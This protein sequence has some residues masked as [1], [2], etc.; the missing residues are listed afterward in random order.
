MKGGSI[1]MTSDASRA[2]GDAMRVI[3]HPILTICYATR[4]TGQ[5]MKVTSYPKIVGIT[6]GCVIPRQRGKVGHAR[7]VTR[8]S[9]RRADKRPYIEQAMSHVT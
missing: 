7:P 3:S 5:D 2:T 4:V 6:M 9:L 8:A 1:R